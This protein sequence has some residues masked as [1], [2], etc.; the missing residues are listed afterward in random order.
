MNRALGNEWTQ[1]AECYGLHWCRNNLSRK[2]V[3]PHKNRPQLHRSLLVR[4]ARMRGQDVRAAWADASGAL[5][6]HIP[7]A[8][9]M[10]KEHW[11]PVTAAAAG[12]YCLW[13]LIRFIR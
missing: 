11:L 9:D 7:V 4:Q 5:K 6:K 10:L 2:H 1:R 3:V 8:Q 13:R 12:L